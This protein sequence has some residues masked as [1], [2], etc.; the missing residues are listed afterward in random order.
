MAQ[1]ENIFQLPLASPLTT[2]GVPAS[3]TSAPS[4]AAASASISTSTS[5]AAAASA[6]ISTST[7]ASASA[8]ASTSS[9]SSTL[10]AQTKTDSDTEAD[11]DMTMRIGAGVGIPFG[12]L[13][14]AMIGLLFWRNARNNKRIRE[15]QAHVVEISRGQGGL[16]AYAPG[17]MTG[18]YRP[19]PELESSMGG[20]QVVEMESGHCQKT[21]E[22]D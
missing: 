17:Y 5:T 19:R 8:S 16:N 20:R 6:S 1:R 15:L 4:S 21:A 9:T 22:L 12:V 13:A 11:N 10:E 14:L 3:S 2:I 7:A 18:P